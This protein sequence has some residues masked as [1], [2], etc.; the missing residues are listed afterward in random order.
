MVVKH[1]QLNSVKH[2]L[3]KILLY[4]KCIVHYT[5]LS[6]ICST[7]SSLHTYCHVLIYFTCVRCGVSPSYCVIT[8]LLTFSFMTLLIRH[9]ECTKRLLLSCTVLVTSVYCI[10][11]NNRS[12]ESCDKLDQFSATFL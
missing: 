11:S 2:I 5:I 7:L 3:N 6:I 1:L 4:V 9:S 10:N 12:M 8:P